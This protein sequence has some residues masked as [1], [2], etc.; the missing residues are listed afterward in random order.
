MSGSVRVVF[1][2]A[3]VTTDISHLQQQVGIS[4]ALLGDFYYRIYNPDGTYNFVYKESLQNSSSLDVIEKDTESVRLA[5]TGISENDTDIENTYIH[6]TTSN[7]FTSSTSSISNYYT[8]L[9]IVTISYFDNSGNS[10]IGKSVYNDGIFEGNHI[11]KLDK[12]TFTVTGA[13]GKFKNAN[14]IVIEYLNDR[15][16]YP[17]ICKVYS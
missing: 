8:E 9:I 6:I 16:Y 1:D 10:V 2:P 13:T 7:I 4:G 11:A 15:T 5:V 14:T 3:T 17:R 12:V